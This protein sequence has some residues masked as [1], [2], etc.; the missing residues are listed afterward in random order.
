MRIVAHILSLL[1][2]LASGAAAILGVATFVGAPTVFQEIGALCMLLIATTL[3]VACAA[4]ALLE[5]AGRPPVLSKPERRDLLRAIGEI[6]DRGYDTVD[7]LDRIDDR[8]T[9]NNSAAPPAPRSR[10]ASR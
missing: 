10:A 4:F 3:L 5:I 2:M 7:R 9:A 6:R 1:C 8:L